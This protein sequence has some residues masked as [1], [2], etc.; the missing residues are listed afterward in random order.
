[1]NCLEGIIATVV[2]HARICR[3]AIEFEVPAAWIPRE[4]RRRRAVSHRKNGPC[5]FLHDRIPPPQWGG[6]WGG[7]PGNLVAEFVYFGSQLV[8][9][10]FFPT[11][12]FHIRCEPRYL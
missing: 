4:P 7:K 12:R 2:M 8:G 9:P 1:M 6:R 3:R 5:A 10:S 11:K